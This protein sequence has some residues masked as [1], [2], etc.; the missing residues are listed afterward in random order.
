[1]RTEMTSQE[2]DTLENSVDID[3]GKDDLSTP[4]KI[5]P[6]G[7]FGNWIGLTVLC[8]GVLAFLVEMFRNPNYEW[9]VVLQYLFSPIVLK[10]LGLTIWLTI[11]AMV[12]GVAISVIVAVMRL[13][14]KTWLRI[15][16]SLY[17]W[18]FRGTPLLVQLIFWYN[19]AFLYPRVYL[20]LP[21]G[22]VLLDISTNDL[23]TPLIAALL[24]LALNE[25][26]YM[27]EIVRS[28]IL[29]VDAGQKE[30]ARALGMNRGKVFRRIILPQSIRIIIPPT[31]NQLIM[32]LK[33]TSMV[34]VIAM[35]D[36]LYAVQS[37]SSRTFQTMPL[38][39]VASLW[40][41]FL[42][43]VAGFGQQRLERH[44]AARSNSGEH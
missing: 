17:L 4:L 2:T 39:I 5:V 7:R 14:D 18:F 6:T 34:S 35:Y 43:S 28:G 1:M 30:A 40:Y 41:L 27:A 42:T 12:I 9:D 25:G 26:A 29:S 37:I 15:P 19:L 3:V 22:P 20:A 21:G 16:A 23:I 44:F 24:G 31:G 33:M 38:L 13:S 8:F 32:M 36:L 10:G 11:V